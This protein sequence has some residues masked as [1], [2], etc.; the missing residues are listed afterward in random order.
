VIIIIAEAPRNIAFFTL[1][2]TTQKFVLLGRSKVIKKLIC[3]DF[4]SRINK[5]YTLE[6][7]P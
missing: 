2:I 3:T 6:R 5:N 7:V 4:I 1:K